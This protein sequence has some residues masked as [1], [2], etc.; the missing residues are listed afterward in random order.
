MDDI[1][2][3][4]SHKFVWYEQCC[5][6]EIKAGKYMTSFY[7]EEELK[8]IGFQAIGKDVLI[9]RKVSIYG[10]AHI[11]IG[12][13]VRIDDFCILSGYLVLGSYIHIAAYT[14]LYGGNI[15]G[16]LCELI[17]QSDCLWRQ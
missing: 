11:S 1:D 9:S 17:L 8:Q 2:F 5:D 12:N 15:Y 7:A 10:A 3:A 13:H 14:A 4:V 6:E 16:R